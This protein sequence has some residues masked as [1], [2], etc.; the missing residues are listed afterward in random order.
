[1]HNTRYSNDVTTQLHA[2]DFAAEAG[3]HPVAYTKCW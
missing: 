1:L 3:I 2:H